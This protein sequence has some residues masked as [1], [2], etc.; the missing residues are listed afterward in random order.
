MLI[1]LKQK[2]TT[3]TTTTKNHASNV[4]S[5]VKFYLGTVVKYT[6]NLLPNYPLY[7]EIMTLNEKAN[8]RRKVHL[9]INCM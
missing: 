6:V 1:P 5:R 7:L 4:P 3:A 8:P 9:A 2:T